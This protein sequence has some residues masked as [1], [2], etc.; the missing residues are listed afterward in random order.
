[1]FINFVCVYIVVFS[2][3]E[4][5]PSE[6]KSEFTIG[7]VIDLF[8]E[9]ENRLNVEISSLRDHLQVEK[10]W[11]RSIQSDL[12]TA[13]HKIEMLKQVV[14]KKGSSCL[15]ARY[16]KI[17]N[18]QQ[19]IRKQNNK[20]E[21]LEKKIIK[22]NNKMEDFK[23]NIRKQNNKM[24]DLEKKI[25]KQNNKIEYLEKEIQNKTTLCSCNEENTETT[26]TT[27]S[28]VTSTTTTKL[29]PT[30]TGKLP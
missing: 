22:Q 20:M 19:N 16:K 24:E 7:N 4:F 26:T 1:M 27:S 14:Q 29:T 21:D 12:K 5:T 28:P 9:L 25:V 13:N 2:I 6:V 11:R 8:T 10:V 30:T 17:E 23:Q 18:L 15:D 3:S